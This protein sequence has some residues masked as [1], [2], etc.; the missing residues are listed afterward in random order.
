MVLILKRSKHVM[1]ELRIV[2]DCSK[3]E[4]KTWQVSFR[5]HTKVKD[6]VML[7]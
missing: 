6:M 4:L 3:F 2:I 1:V 5:M 7:F